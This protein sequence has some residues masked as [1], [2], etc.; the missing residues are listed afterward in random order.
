MIWKNYQTCLMLTIKCL[1]YYV[2]LNWSYSN[3]DVKKLDFGFQIKWNGKK[4]FQS[5]WADHL[6]E[7]REYVS[8]DTLRFI[9]YAIFDSLLNH[10]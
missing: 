1:Q 9:Y 7:K 6:R 8:T 3:L 4:P 2:K 10:F 5:N